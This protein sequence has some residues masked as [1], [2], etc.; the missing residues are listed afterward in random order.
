[1][2]TSQSEHRRD[3]RVKG[4]KRKQVKEA[5]WTSVRTFQV[6]GT[7]VAAKDGNNYNN[8]IVILV[9]TNVLPP[10]SSSPSSPVKFCENIAGSWHP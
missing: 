1:M 3:R 5:A 4:G 8:H 7:V 9:I 6:A 10:S 2:F